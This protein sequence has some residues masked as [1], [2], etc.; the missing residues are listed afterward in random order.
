MHY[1]ILEARK[2]SQP[3]AKAS[4]N[5]QRKNYHFQCFICTHR[6]IHT[7]THDYISMSFNT[8]L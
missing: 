3:P 1:D 4:S 8:F 5:S 7:Q 6:H 2:N